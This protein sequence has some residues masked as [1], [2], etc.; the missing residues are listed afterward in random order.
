MESNMNIS[1][2]ES[3]QNFLPTNEVLVEFTKKDGTI[4]KM[5]CTKNP[6][7]IP[8]EATPKGTGKQKVDTTVSVYDTEVKGWRSFAKDSLISFTV[9]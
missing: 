8:V 5:R 3:L 9:L 4:R 6:S 2:N 1:L 7:L